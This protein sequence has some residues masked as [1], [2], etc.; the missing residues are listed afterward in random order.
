MHSLLSTNKCFYNIGIIGRP[1]NR[2]ITP[3]PLDRFA[4]NLVYR[5]IMSQ[6]RRNFT[7]VQ[8]GLLP[9][10]FG[11]QTLFAN[12]LGHLIFIWYID[13]FRQLKA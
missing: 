2:A 11:G 7:F 3:K 13:F 1:A 8:I 4:S 9:G 5:Y 6:R 12:K 10:G